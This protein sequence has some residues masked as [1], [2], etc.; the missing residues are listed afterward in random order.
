MGSPPLQ[1]EQFAAQLSA[2][3]A[4]VGA[5]TEF[6]AAV[7]AEADR[8]VAHRPSFAG[9]ADRT[10]LGLVTIDPPGAMDLDQAIHIA[11]H[12]TGF[13]V[14]YAIADV[15]AWLSPGGE[16]DRE[17]HARGQTLYGPGF[18]VPVHPPVLSEGAISLLADGQIRPAMLW[19]LDLDDEGRL[20]ASWLTR[21]MVRSREQLSYEEAQRRIDAGEASESLRLLRE[22]GLL[23]AKLET[24]RG[25]ISLNLPDQEVVSAGD[26]FRAEFRAGLPV[27]AWNAQISLLTGAAAAELMLDAEVGILRTLPAAHP[28]DVARLRL[29]VASL[30]ID[31]PTN[32]TYPAFIDSLDPAEPS[33]LA[34]LVACTTLFRGAGYVSFAGELPGGDLSHGAL[35]MNYAHT[36]APLRRLVDRYVLEICHAIANGVPVAEWA[37]A[38]LPTLPDEMR[39][40]ERRARKFERGVID[41]VEVLQLQGRLGEVFE[42][43]VLSVDDDDGGSGTIQLGAPAVTAT[44]QRLTSEDHGRRVL[45]RLSELDWEA[46]RA[47]FDMV[48][49]VDR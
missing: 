19:E 11:R 27:E 47:T 44:A 28:K 14:S 41:L 21:A 43:V 8:L 24:A 17:A 40:S 16:V 30:S 2:L 4:E 6:P 9:H 5:P 15:G 42:A 31:W 3:Q 38:A 35:A 23:R 20:R 1:P 10:E 34:M 36:T 48:G 37:L 26:G 29:V 25:G 49:R 45:V 12:G 13:R 18:R 39:A 7:L 33:H 32:I 22:V 46:R